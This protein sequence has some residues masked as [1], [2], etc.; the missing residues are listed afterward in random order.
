MSSV[1]VKTKRS[2]GHNGERSV[3]IASK[4]GENYLPSA[5][6]NSQTDLLEMKKY[7]EFVNNSTILPRKYHQLME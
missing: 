1:K 2:D 7:Q 4:L 6:D 3:V 5:L